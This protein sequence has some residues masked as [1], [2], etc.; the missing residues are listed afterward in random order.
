MGTTEPGVFMVTIPNSTSL[1]TIKA[2]DFWCMVSRWNG[3][4]V[5][6][7][8]NCYQ[9]TFL[10]LD[11]LRRGGRQFFKRQ[12]PR[13]SMRS[14]AMWLSVRHRPAPPARASNPATPTAAILE[15][16]GSDP[17]WKTVA[18][19]GLSDDVANAYTLLTLISHHSTRCLTRPTVFYCGNTTS[20]IN[21]AVCRLLPRPM[22]NF[23]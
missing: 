16:R 12:P 1:Q 9:I 13:W 19:T 10:N 6:S 5:Y 14:T 18:F 15:T 17:G 7:A 22:M 20:P 8:E 4:S 2:G 11:R 21:P 3:S 23:G